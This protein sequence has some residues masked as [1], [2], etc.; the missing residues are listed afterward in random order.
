ML[1]KEEVEELPCDSNGNNSTSDVLAKLCT[2]LEI[3]LQNGTK[4]KT[5]PKADVLNGENN[6]QECEYCN[7]ELPNKRLLKNH[8]KDCHKQEIQYICTFCNRE[9]KK[10][11]HLKEHIAS[12]TGEKQYSCDICGKTFQRMSSRSRH[13]KSHDKAPG[14]KSKR[15]PF[16]CTICGKKFPFSNSVQRHMRM[17]M[18]IKQHECVVC[19]KRFNQ[20]THLNVHMRTHTGE[21]P[22]ICDLC[23]SAFAL[24]ATLQRH[25]MASHPE[26]NESVSERKIKT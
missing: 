1:V 18:G 16:L 2:E 21:K 11:F 23:G 9:F 13:M 22:Y 24:N 4:K 25:I 5:K 20:T 3:D 26:R 19:Q 7:M 10:S 15:T 17:H 12:H 8:V 14:Q 6:K